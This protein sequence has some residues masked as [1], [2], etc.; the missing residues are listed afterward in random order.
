V[1]QELRQGQYLVESV[2]I[3]PLPPS[4]IVY[5]QQV[6]NNGAWRV[7]SEV[8]NITSS[9]TTLQD[10]VFESILEDNYVRKREGKTPFPTPSFHAT[11]NGILLALRN[12]LMIRD[13]LVTGAGESPREDR[14]RPKLMVWEKEMVKG[15][16]ENG[17]EVE[18]WEGNWEEVEFPCDEG[19]EEDW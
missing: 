5:F 8:G 10:L 13:I 2:P 1:T 16:D 3:Y 17:V 18:K 9:T 6:P 7:K 14:D 12:V 19:Y 15:V 4:K 11:N